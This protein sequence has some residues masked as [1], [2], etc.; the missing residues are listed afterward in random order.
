[1]HTL[2]MTFDVYRETFSPTG[3]PRDRRVTGESVRVVQDREF[4]QTSPFLFFKLRFFFST[5]CA[6]PLCNSFACIFTLWRTRSLPYP[7]I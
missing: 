5:F 6:S 2:K 1:M 3:A 7:A 4:S